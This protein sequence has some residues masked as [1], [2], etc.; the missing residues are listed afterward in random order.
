MLSVRVP[1]STSNLGAG[2]DCLGLALEVWLEARVVSG[3]GSPQFTGTVAEL[4][5]TTDLV[6]QIIGDA[7]PHDHHVEM[8]SD[9]PVSRG[10]G[11]SGA[12]RV[13]GVVLRTSLLERDVERDSVFWD[14][15]NKE[16]HPDNVGPSVYGGL[17]LSSPDPSVLEM[18]PL[19]AIALAI[20]ESTINTE[21][22]RAI[23]PDAIPR[24]DAVSQAAGAAALVYGL[25][26]GEPDL[27]R[28]GFADRIAAPHRSKLIPGYTQA[29]D[30][31][32]E[33]GAFGVTVSGSG[34]GVLAV[35]DAALAPAVA[36][37]MAD[38]LTAAGT[39]SEALT[40]GINTTGY[41]VIG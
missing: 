2:F 37:A 24:G 17:V 1:A 36:T 13:A 14:A 23:L 39:L 18:D 5:P 32:I 34:P 27:V 41:E 30:A 31:G 4:T 7:L 8:H 26:R 33:A 29:V 21:E 10:L 9:I 22:A 16:G 6:N 40:P 11:S 35:A 15:C 20:P 28:R 38:A 19:F 25:S 12:A 3:K